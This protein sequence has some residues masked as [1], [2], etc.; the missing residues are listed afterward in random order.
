M[1]NFR[2]FII[3]W[4]VGLL[5]LGCMP[6]PAEATVTNQT[7]RESLYTG[8]N[9]TVAFTF[10]FPIDRGS[11]GDHED[12]EV[13]LITTATGVTDE[14]TETTE[15]AVSATN[16]NFASGGTVTMVTAPT[17]AQQLLIIRATPLTQN[18]SIGTSGILLTLQNTV[19]KLQKQIIDLQEEVNRSPKFPKT[20]ATTLTAT[21]PGSVD[22]AGKNATFG[23]DG[24][25]TATD[26]LS[27]GE[28]NI[29]AFGQNL[30][31]D[32]SASAAQTTLLLKDGSAALDL[33]SLDADTVTGTDVNVAN[34]ITKSPWVDVR[35]YGSAMTEVVVQAAV[36]AAEAVGYGNILIPPGEWTFS[37]AVT[38]RSDNIHIKG[39][40]EGVTV[41]EA[42][43]ATTNI[44]EFGNATVQVYSR[45][46]IS[47]LS[48][49]STNYTRSAGAAIDIDAMAW[50]VVEDVW[51]ESHFYGIYIHTDG[52]SAAQIKAT[53]PFR[54]YINRCSIRDIIPTTG[55]GIY[56][57]HLL[58]GLYIT[59]TEIAASSDG[60]DCLAGI[61][62]DGGLV[63]S[64]AGGGYIFNDV[65][66]AYCA[67]GLHI[68]PAENYTVKWG[69]FTNCQFDTGYIGVFV[70]SA[71]VTESLFFNHCWSVNNQRQG[72]TLSENG[73]TTMTIRFDSCRALSNGRNGFEIGTGC[74]FIDIYN[75][76]ASGNSSTNHES[77][78]VYHGI[79]FAPTTNNFSITDCRAEYDGSSYWGD[80]Q[81]YGIYIQG[82]TH[83][84]YIITGNDTTTNFTAS[85]IFDA[86]T[87]S[88]EKIVE[89]NLPFL[90]SKIALLSTTTVSLAADA[91][92]VVFTVP[93]GK[94]CVLT[95]AWLVAGA[96]AGT[97]D[98]SIGAI[99]SETDWVGVHNLDNVN[100]QYDV[101]IIKP[102]ASSTPATLKSYAATTV[103][104]AQVANQAGGATN[105]LYLFG[106]LY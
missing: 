92:T 27:T 83:A 97:S 41:I 100:A 16:N 88:G 6:V 37:A 73:G 50:F 54:L 75:C 57:K 32:A 39:A 15:Y 21:Y 36:D 9:S 18:S 7:N 14:L 69:F 5:G 23:L 4:I 91:N 59:D 76:Q 31:D 95:E 85:G 71:G 106:Y 46:S 90:P 25:V 40:G 62:L 48:I 86:G 96:N 60:A 24:S 104:N 53:L 42:G 30:I 94:R 10:S 64:N 80:T 47:D 11:S 79:T 55:I 1:L 34:L 63:T 87:S 98:I 84:D 19:D 51:I 101:C 99:E 38:I 44:F 82:P 56:Q 49:K 66:T 72:F 3:L 33:L 52:S 65:D 29:S 103:I 81:G 78:G 45:N 77:V 28:A 17:T 105:T 93:A 22:R 61:K 35:A 20:D 68:A 43:D 12:L 74:E 67:A 13:W 70:N 89:D 102:V 58:S 2:M 26:Q 8:D